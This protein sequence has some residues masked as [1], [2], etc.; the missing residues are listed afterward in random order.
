MTQIQEKADHSWPRVQ[1]W[2]LS[3]IVN[4]VLHY[5]HLL[6]VAILFCNQ[7]IFEIVQ[8]MLFKFCSSSAKITITNL[9]SCSSKK[10]DYYQG[11]ILLKHMPKHF[12]L[13]WTN[14]NLESFKNLNWKQII[15]YWNHWNLL[16]SF[17]NLWVNADLTW[18]S[19]TSESTEQKLKKLSPQKPQYTR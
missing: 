3:D 10:C 13:S 16:K 9:P 6:T 11:E 17:K 15:F 4:L 14:L 18:V 5:C 2:T 1:F 19:K 7:T 12:C 8:K